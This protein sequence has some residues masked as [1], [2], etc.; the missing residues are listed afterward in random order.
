MEFTLNNCISRIN[1][2]LN[3]PAL[4]YSDV[5][6]FLDQAIYEL[7]TSLRIALPTVTEMLYENTVKA[8]SQP[9]LVKIVDS[10]VMERNKEYATDTYSYTYLGG[11]KFKITRNGE[12]TEYDGLY[13]YKF[14]AENVPVYYVT[15][16]VDNDAAYWQEIKETSVDFD[17]TEY[18]PFDWWTLF[19]IPYT[20]S[21]WANRNGDDSSHF[22]DEYIQGYQQLQT[23]YNVPNR[24]KLSEVAG[25][26]AYKKLVEE[27]LPHLNAVVFTRAIYEDMKV[28]N[29]IMPSYGGFY[30]TGGWGV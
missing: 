11:S 7:N 27:R 19:I 24:V 29:G 30:E 13:G 22:I 28:G 16:T 26:K 25:R 21:K 3:Y 5:Y 15:V 4:S 6:H 12:T 8:H 23:S 17:V 10:G 20:C 14:S 18:L 2:A 9:N 1:Q